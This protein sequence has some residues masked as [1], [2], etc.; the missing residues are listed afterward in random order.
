MHAGRRELS[1]VRLLFVVCWVGLLL[2]TGGCQTRSS[3]TE[4][5]VS[6]DDE[7]EVDPVN[8]VATPRDPLPNDCQGQDLAGCACH[9]CGTATC[10][11]CMKCVPTRVP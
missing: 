7:I 11:A 1:T 6:S 5:A 8:C 3:A 10:S 2:A 4:A 9:C